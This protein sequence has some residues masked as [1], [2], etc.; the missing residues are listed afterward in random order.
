M[1]RAKAA[2]PA[3]DDGVDA[4]RRAFVVL[5]G[6]ALVVRL[7]YFTQ[8]IRVPIF[9]RLMMDGAVY[10][11][12]AGRIASGD[13]RG[14]EVFYQAPLY[15][16]LL[17]LLKLGGAHGLWPIRILQALLGSLSCGLLFLAAQ[18]FFSRRVGL[19][20]GALLAFYPPAIFFDGVVQKA[21]VGGF[22][23]V[24]LLWCLAR[25]KDAPS[26]ARFGACGLA[27]GLL[28]LTREETLLL[29]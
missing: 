26:P 24:L 21:S 27:L 20:A 4:T 19:I 1:S 23:V 29:A 28:M 18:S 11:A 12:W 16:Y 13:W 22:F 2:E 5:V 8:A 3:P 9:D 25:A 7:L 15:P 14:G 17:A 10:D 6:I